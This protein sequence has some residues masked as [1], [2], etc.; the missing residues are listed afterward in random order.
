MKPKAWFYLSLVTIFILLASPTMAQNAP[1]S[2]FDEDQ[3]VSWTAG[4]ANQPALRN[5]NASLATIQVTSLEDNTVVDG[6]CTLREALQAASTH[7]AV[8]ACQQGNETDNTIT[9]S[10]TGTIMLVAEDLDVN[11][12]G[13]SLLIDGGGEITISGGNNV[14][15]FTIGNLAN[16]TMKNLS[17]IDGSA[18]D[19]GGIY[20]NNIVSILNS[21]LADNEASALTGM[22]GGIYNN[23]GSVSIT[24]STLNGNHAA[25]GGAIYSNTGYL[26]ITNS[27]LSGNNALS[28]GGG[29]YSTGYITLYNATVAYNVA[30]VDGGG[31]YTQNVTLYLRNSILAEN[32]ASENGPECYVNTVTTSGYNLVGNTS[33]CGIFPWTGD[34]TNVGAEL[35]PLQDNGGPTYTHALLPGSLAI[36]HGNRNG[37]SGSSTE[38]LTDQRGMPRSGRCDIGAFEWQPELAGPHSVYLPCLSGA[39]PSKLYFDD[40]SN[41]SSGWKVMENASGRYEYLDG[42]YRILAKVAVAWESSFT[43]FKANNYVVKVDVRN[44]TD[45]NGYSGLLFSFAPD[46]S[47]F[48]YY[49]INN[50]GRYIIFEWDLATSY[51]IATGNSNAIHWGSTPNHLSLER[52]GDMIWAFANGEL[53]T[54]VRD[55]AFTGLGFVG[56]MVIADPT[57][58]VDARFDNFTIEPISC[59]ASYNYPLLTADTYQS[60][61]AMLTP[62]EKWLNILQLWQVSK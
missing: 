24:N 46:W 38:L 14:R 10:V 33:A 18:P 13:G 37:C 59:G 17:I 41:P 27:T 21:T 11:T 6:L 23:G 5:E 28:N 51:F 36:N 44:V 30:G 32:T 53:L 8:D 2:S 61:A 57:P 22:G 40:F 48:Y 50:A 42:E 1:Q 29:I 7:S 25:S 3:G 55:N 16:V 58:N 35:G 19:G 49:G 52:N 54:V 56:L 31:I 45:I 43:G 26:A 34:L 4:S 47:R 20:N 62:T 60:E 39:C 15:V 12:V 9:F